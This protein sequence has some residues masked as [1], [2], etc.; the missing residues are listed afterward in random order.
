MTYNEIADVVK[1]HNYE[2]PVIGYTEDDERI[3]I[4]TNNEIIYVDNEPTASNFYDVFLYPKDG[5]VRHYKYY[6]INVVVEIP[7]E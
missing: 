4:N 1:K 3:V 6:D 2:F 5:S 7:V